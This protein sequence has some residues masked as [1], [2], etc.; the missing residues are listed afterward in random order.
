MSIQEQAKQYVAR[1]GI[2][3]ARHSN[4]YLTALRH[5][6]CGACFCCAVRREVDS[7]RN[8]EREEETTY[9]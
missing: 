4:H 8:D 5:C 9:E 3:E 1:V 2:D 6:R 7:R